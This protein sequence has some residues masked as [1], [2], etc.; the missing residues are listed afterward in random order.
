MN[1]AHVRHRRGHPCVRQAFSAARRGPAKSNG[2][3]ILRVT[4]VESGSYEI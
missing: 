2:L 3:P 1:S 4:P